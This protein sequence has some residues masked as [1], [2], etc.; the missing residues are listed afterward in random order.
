MKT[1]KD[2]FVPDDLWYFVLA[3]LNRTRYQPIY[4]RHLEKYDEK[5][6]FPQY[7][8]S[9]MESDLFE[10]LAHEAVIYYMQHMEDITLENIDKYGDK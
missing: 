8:M 7:S 10:I 3:Y 2:K 6:G 1:I 9:W 5:T 4:D